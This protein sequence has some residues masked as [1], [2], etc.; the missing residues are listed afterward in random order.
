MNGVRA[1]LLL[2]ALGLF[3]AAFCWSPIPG[4][5]GFAWIALA[6]HAL[7]NSEAAPALGKLRV[8]AAVLAWTTSALWLLI[9][10]LGPITFFDPL[11]QSPSLCCAALVL[12]RLARVDRASGLARAFALFAWTS[13]VLV[14]L[15]LP[16]YMIFLVAMP[17][18]LLITLT[19]AG[20]T[21]GLRARL[22]TAGK[23]I[24]WSAS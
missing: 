16:P 4:I 3:L 22:A 5:L 9:V 15:R 10:F 19:L 13:L 23:Y 14:P 8:A 20:L 1:P 6:L 24:P 2:F 7:R 11:T 18:Q 12:A 17:L 21:L